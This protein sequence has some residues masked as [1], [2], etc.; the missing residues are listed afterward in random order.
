MSKTLLLTALGLGAALCAQAGDIHGKVTC[1]GVRDSADAVV[2][3]AAIPGKTF[4]APAAHAK[5]DQ[6]NLV[7]IPHVMAVLAGTT[8]DYLNSDAVLHNVFSPDACC[9]KFNLG[10]WPQGQSKSYTFKKECAATLLCKVHP[11]MEGFVVTSPTPYFAVTKADG[12]FTIPNVP[13]GAYTV[14]VWHPK[15]KPSQKAV[16]V[17][18]ATAAAFEIA[19]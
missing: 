13:D 6:K 9:D 19:K 15:C 1:K 3:V 8:V 10:T 14:K 4:A 5:M 16:T 11:E 7:F 12:S 18:G 2:Y 17:A